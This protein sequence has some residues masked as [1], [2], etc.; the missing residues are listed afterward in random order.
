M[1]LQECVWPWGRG[2]QEMEG[3]R[4]RLCLLHKYTCKIGI[5]RY[6]KS[7]FPESA[8]EFVLNTQQNDKEVFYQ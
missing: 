2:V 1:Q 3:G 7:T 5:L 6:Y 8:N 4:G